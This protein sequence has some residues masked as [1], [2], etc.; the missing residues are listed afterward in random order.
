MAV[1]LAELCLNGVIKHVGAAGTHTLATGPDAAT[2]GPETVTQ[3]GPV[4]RLAPDGTVASRTMDPRTIALTFDDGPDP[5]W[6]P[7]VLDLL[8]QHHAHATLPV[9]GSKVTDY[10]DLTRR[11][12]A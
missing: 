5:Q 8:A 6:T 9:L 12:R 2:V 1:L 7:K 10:P 4:L 3:A 11:T